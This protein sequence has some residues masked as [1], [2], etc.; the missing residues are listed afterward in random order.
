MVL[1]K[2]N[3]F[4]TFL[5]RSILMVLLCLYFLLVFS[6]PNS[7][8]FHITPPQV[9]KSNQTC[10]L[11]ISKLPKLLSFEGIALNKQVK[12]NWSFET[13]EGLDECIVERADKSGDFKPVAYFFITE[14]IHI[15]NLRFTDNVPKNKTYYYRLKLTGKDG[16]MQYT[17]TLTFDTRAKEDQKKS[18]SYP[19]VMQ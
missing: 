10:C 2:T 17:K 19:L 18:L 16:V 14:D 6:R 5:Y 13:T 3:G 12:L 1:M 15:P 11:P 4:R 8:S 9:N 7:T